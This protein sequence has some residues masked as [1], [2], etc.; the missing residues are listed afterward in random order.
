MGVTPL[1]FPV[2]AARTINRLA[3]TSRHE[4][5]DHPRAVTIV[6]GGEVVR[7]TAHAS[8]LTRRGRQVL[9]CIE[10]HLCWIASQRVRMI[11][12]DQGGPRGDD[13]AEPPRSR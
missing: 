3:E 7:T 8:R 9:V 10:G 13:A 11:A 2:Q 1:S 6:Q 5:F 12:D 4:S